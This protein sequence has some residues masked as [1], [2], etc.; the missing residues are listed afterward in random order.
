MT[1][2]GR[3]DF[4]EEVT[5]KIELAQGRIGEEACQQEERVPR[6][7]GKDRCDSVAPLHPPTG[8]LRDPEG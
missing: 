7:W 3:E 8:F 6:S 2:E 1:A 5:D 4:L